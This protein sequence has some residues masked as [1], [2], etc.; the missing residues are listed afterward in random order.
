MVKLRE[1][2]S[3]AMDLLETRRNL[4][5]GRENTGLTVKTAEKNTF[6]TMDNAWWI[7]LVSF[8]L[9]VLSTIL[10]QIIFRW[11]DGGSHKRKR[12]REIE[13]NRKLGEDL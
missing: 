2:L 5:W 4:I 11:Y 10:V 7:A 12:K 13:S 9:V 6:L 8:G 3:R 1:E